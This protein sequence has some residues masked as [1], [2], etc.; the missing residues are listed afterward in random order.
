MFRK[1]QKRN[2]L[3]IQPSL[4]LKSVGFYILLLS[5]T[6][7]YCHSFKTYKVQ[8]WRAVYF[9]RRRQIAEKDNNRMNFGCRKSLGKLEHVPTGNKT[10]SFSIFK[11]FYVKIK[12][13]NGKRKG[14]EE[15]SDQ[16]LVQ[17]RPLQAV[18]E[19]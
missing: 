5:V 13:L 18:N 17:N 7:R 16:V 12:F 10:D 14:S 15:R 3:L 19:P 6:I 2:N 8:S 4:I 1:A 9:S 11:L